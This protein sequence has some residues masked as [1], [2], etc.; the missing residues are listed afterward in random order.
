MAS[1]PTRI[2]ALDG[3]GIRGVFTAAFL[4]HVEEHLKLRL[5]EHV[6]LLTGTSTGAIIALAL[7]SGLP[8]S[9]VLDSYKTAG[10]LI[11]GKKRNRL[12]SLFM[13]AHGNEALK[14]W[15]RRTFEDKILNDARVPIA[16]PSFDASTGRP[17]VWKRDH[18]QELHG[19]G[20]KK[21]WEVA[22]TSAAAPTYLP[23]AQIEGLGAFLDG[24]LWA[25]NPSLVGLVEARR[26]LESELADIQ[27]LSVGTGRQ[28]RG[29][30]FQDIQ[31]RGQLAWARPLFELLLTAQSVS[32]HEQAQLLLGP[33]QYLRVDQELPH[34]IELDDV[35]EIS[36][37]EH[38]GREAGMRHLQEVKR[39]LRV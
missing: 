32:T 23:A 5:V 3:G 27:L 37:L 20:L 8:A 17:R 38:L 4:A 9:Q 15:L 10:P 25:N 6:E 1:K 24:G 14:E 2:L 13:T 35:R 19:G 33:G 16:I 22:L 28:P 12:L 21:M 18:H 11:F 31:F 26:Y 29:F 36:Q 7:A 34:P 30:R 39:L